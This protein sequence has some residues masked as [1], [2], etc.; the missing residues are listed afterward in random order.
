ML[1]VTKPVKSEINK[2][3]TLGLIGGMSWESTAHY[4]RLINQGIKA[5]KGGLHSAKIIL[6]SVDFAEIEVLQRANNW[7]KSAELLQ[8]AAQ[9][10]EVAGADC[11]LICTNTMHKVASEV[12]ASV[13]IPLL[14]IAE[15]TACE[16]LQQNIHKVALLGTEFTMSERFYRERL[17]QKGIEVLIPTKSERRL[18]HDIIYQ[19]LC[20]GD[21]RESAKHTYL[22]II[23]KLHK[24]GA[25]G[26]ILGCTEIGLLIRQS[27][28]TIPLFDTTEIHAQ[29]AVNFA[30]EAL[31]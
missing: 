2:M 15:V 13:A 22:S 6:N 26:V 20:L 21:I 4:Y 23:D 16:L 14:H 1:R 24:L 8:G 12:S 11:I 17:E 29:A 30:L 28:T 7:Q 31:T 3:K 10:I 25:Q 9:S 19:Q 18:V 27:D 5:K